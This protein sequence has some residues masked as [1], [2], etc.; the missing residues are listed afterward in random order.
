MDQKNLQYFG[1]FDS[2]QHVGA[3]AVVNC[4]FAIDF[5]AVYSAA[6]VMKLHETGFVANCF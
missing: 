5:V 4:V 2:V 6:A 3:T 1:V